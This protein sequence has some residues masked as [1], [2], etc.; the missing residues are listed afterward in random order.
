MSPTVFHRLLISLFL[1]ITG[2]SSVFAQTVSVNGASCSGA[3]VTFGTGTIAINTAGCTGT[4]STPPT[5]TAAAPP[6]GTVSAA[7]TYTF[8]ATGS[9]APTW[10]FSGGT[11]PAGLSLSSA[12]VLSGTPT[13][14]GSSSFTVQAAN[15]ASPNATQSVTVVIAAASGPPVITSNATLPAAVLNQAYNFTFNAT[16]AQPIGWTSTAL[17]AGLTLSAAGVLSGTPTGPAGNIP[18]TVT[19]TNSVT[20]ANLPVTLSIAA[21]IAPVISGTPPATG[22]TGTPYSF[23]FGATGTAPITWSVASGTLP[24]GVTLNASTGALSG[25]P[26]VAGAY[27]FAVQA[28]N[29]GGTTPPTSNFTITIAVAVQGM[30]ALDGTPIPSPSKIAKVLTPLHAGLNGAG[31]NV[32]AYAVDPTR[33]SNTTPAISTSWHHNIDFADHGAKQNLDYFDMGPNEALTYKFTADTL[34]VGSVTIGDSTQVP[35]V[36]TFMS[37]STTPC[38]F[39][40]SK[41]VMG[42]GRSF[43]YSS[44]PLENS[45]AY[46]VTSGN[47][48]FA[49]NCKLIPGNTYYLN[50]RFQ[51]GGTTADS[52][53]PRGGAHCG[54]WLQIRR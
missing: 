5:I 21:P 25:T 10:S 7:Y 49:L 48:S 6:A 20:A 44:Q 13:A 19:A 2:L 54:G 47:V 30:Q 50:V 53:A 22:S 3:T 14:A 45:L 11:L 39:D 9:P 36:A 26:T 29:A 23:T 12:G 18:F 41:L 8:T 4:P 31:G 27:T 16:G 15:G 42:A 1:A 40:A 43:C 32:N 35:L 24:T 46:E 37:L 38:D 28:S 33:C 34:G 17:P 51:Q 52:C